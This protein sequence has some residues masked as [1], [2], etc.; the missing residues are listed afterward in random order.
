MPRR[1][2]MRTRAT[3]GGGASGAASDEQLLAEPAVTAD[4]VPISVMINVAGLGRARGARSRALRRHRPRPHRIPLSARA[5]YCSTRR[6]SSLSIGG[7]SSG[8]RDGR[9][10]SARSTPAATSRSRASPST[11]RRNP[12]LG[13]RGIRL[14]LRASR[15]ASGAAPGARP[16]R[17]ARRRS[18]SCCRWSR[19]RASS[20]RRRVSSTEAIAEVDGERPAGAPS[21]ARHH[22]RG[23]GGGARHRELR[24]RFLLD[25]QQRSD[26]IRDRQRA[27]HRRARRAQ[28]SAQSRR[29]CGSSPRLRAT[30]PHAGDRGQPVRRC[31]R[32]PAP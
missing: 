23:A 25:R 16:R 2:G 13:M 22:G 15:G 6:R 24:R 31:R 18:R 27:R 20:R 29:A 4:G 5:A 7:S 1:D 32:R 17:G 12:F 21:A 30:A 28:R 11:A 19:C 14:S 26:A 8:R 9:S 10:R 3:Q